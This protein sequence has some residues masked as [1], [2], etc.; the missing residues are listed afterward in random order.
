MYLLEYN[1][2]THH[3]IFT[4]LNRVDP[5]CPELILMTQH[6]PFQL[7]TN[8]NF[9]DWIFVMFT[10]KAD[11]G[12][13]LF[14]NG[15]ERG[16]VKDSIELQGHTTEKSSNLIIGHSNILETNNPEPKPVAKLYISICTLSETVVTKVEATRIFVYYWGHSKLLFTLNGWLF[17]NCI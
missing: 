11:K 12:L 6:F 5:S 13:T 3:S 7:E 2:I 4:H 17:Y 15:A 16:S 14:I 10:W 8:V 9:N 1:K